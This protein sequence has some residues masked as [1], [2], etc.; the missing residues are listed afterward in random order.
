MSNRRTHEGRA[1]RAAGAW[2]TAI[3]SRVW[4][5]GCPASFRAQ[6]WSHW[7]ATGHGLNFEINSDYGTQTFETKVSLEKNLSVNTT[8]KQWPDTVHLGGSFI[9][10]QVGVHADD[11]LDWCPC[12]HLIQSSLPWCSE[13]ILTPYVWPSMVWLISAFVF[14][15]MP[16]SYCLSYC[17]YV[18]PGFWQSKLVLEERKVGP[19]KINK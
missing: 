5:K 14:A 19:R 16:L 2:P 3:K 8:I 17:Q 18:V 12:T 10:I 11:Y 9:S 4:E 6:A 13:I 1:R 15:E 7:A